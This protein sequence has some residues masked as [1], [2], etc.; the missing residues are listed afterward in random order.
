MGIIGA[1]GD[2]ARLAFVFAGGG[3]LGAVQVGMLRALARRGLR[4]DLVVGSSVGAINAA[5]FG[6]SPDADGVAGLE[7]V[8]A[9]ITRRTIFPFSPLK[10]LMGLMALGDS[11]C[12]PD[13]LRRMLMDNLPYQKLEEAPVPVHAV[14]TDLA[15]GAEVCI[16]RGSAV[17][18][19]VASAAIPGIFPPVLMEGRRVID[20]GVASNTPIPVA[21]SLG[22]TQVL[23][24]PAGYA[25][26]LEKQPKAPIAVVLNALNQILCRALAVDI[27][28]FSRD[29]EIA[30]IPPVCP[31]GVTSTDFSQTPELMERGEAQAQTWLDAGALSTQESPEMLLPHD[32][33]H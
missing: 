7:R 28:R 26:A 11:L 10:G 15:S 23:V 1:G 25:C 32:H 5:Y 4:P 22:A 14:A 18:A 9:G 8:W 2:G 30:V 13:G 31:L 19:L 6:W 16:S 12:S 33:D 27:E 24:L 17:D 20:G 21:A 3:S 29:L